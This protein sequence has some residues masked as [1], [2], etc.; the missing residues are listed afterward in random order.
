MTYALVIDDDTGLLD[1]VRA[2]VQQKGLEVETASTW[3]EGL[4]LF[5]ILSPDLIIADYNMPGSKHG[6]K[7]LA[8]V[9][10][11]RPSVRLILMSAF[12]NEEDMDDISGLGLVD[13]AL[14]KGSS[15]ATM[16]V[17]LEEIDQAA[18][19]ADHKTDW[20]EFVKAHVSAQS[21]S[22]EALDELDSTL[23]RTRL[24]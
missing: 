22:S 8:E 9:R 3:D 14:T 2:T 4:A 13:R 12:L 1:S 11:L 20:V 23:T 19:A 21:V 7:L 6:L 24:N 17:L 16:K 18:Q 5:H 10:H 15:I